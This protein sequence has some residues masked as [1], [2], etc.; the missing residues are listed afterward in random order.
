MPDLPKLPLP[1]ANSIL[2]TSDIAGDYQENINHRTQK[3]TDNDNQ[4]IEYRKNN[5][6]VIARGLKPA[7]RFNIQNHHTIHPS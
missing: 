5:A 1:A 7:G 4:C 3:N 2:S 6:R